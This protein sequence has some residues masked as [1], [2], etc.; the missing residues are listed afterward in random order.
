M[1]AKSERALLLLARDCDGEGGY[2][3][4]IES[5]NSRL[6]INDCTDLLNAVAKKGLADVIY[7]DRHGEPFVYVRLSRKGQTFLAEGK[8]RRS[9]LLQKLLLAAVSALVTFLLGKLLYGIFS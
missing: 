3:V 5:L 2:L 8:R 1:S 4:S 9:V 7:T 6:E